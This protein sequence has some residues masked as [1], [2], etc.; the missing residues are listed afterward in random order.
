MTFENSPNP[1]CVKMR[2]CK[3]GKGALLLLRANL[4][5]YH[6]VYTLSSKHTYRPMRERVEA[7]LLGSLITRVFETRTAIGKEHFAC[8]DSGV[9]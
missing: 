9:S 1:P 2:L 5:R 7:Q 6:R 8:Q 3:Q 4:K